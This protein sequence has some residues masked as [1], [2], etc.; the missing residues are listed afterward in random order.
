MNVRSV[1]TL[2]KL[3]KDTIIVCLYVDDMLIMGRSKDI[4]NAT[5]KMLSDKI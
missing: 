2:R 5:K 1:S 4:I 3:K